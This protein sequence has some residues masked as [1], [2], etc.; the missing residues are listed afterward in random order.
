MALKQDGTLWSWGNN[1]YGQLGDGT[2]TTRLARAE[3]GTETT[4]WA[5]AAGSYHTLALKAD[6]TLWAWGTNWNGQVGDGSRTDRHA[7]IQ[8]GSGYI[9]MEGGDDHTVAVKGGRDALDLGLQQPR[10]ARRDLHLVGPALPGEDRDG[11]H[12]DLGDRGHL[13]HA[14]AAGERDALGQRLQHVRPAR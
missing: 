1:G 7:P 4:W 8:V 14:G 10:R 6:G 13:R 11:D 12:V 5:V 9:A 2:T 3:I